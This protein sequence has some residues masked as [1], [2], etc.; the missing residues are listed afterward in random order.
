MTYVGS[1]LL[2]QAALTADPGAHS[3]ETNDNTNN[4][5][6]NYAVT[7]SS[8]NGY[9]SSATGITW[10]AV[11]KVSAADIARSNSFVWIVENDATGSLASSGSYW[12]RVHGDANG[13]GNGYVDASNTVT[14]YDIQSAQGSIVPG[15]VYHIAFSYDKTKGG[16]A[17][18]NGAASG[19]N[20]ATWAPVWA[21]APAPFF[22]ATAGTTPVGTGN[23][24]YSKQT[25]ISDVA[26][27]AK[28]LPAS[29]MAAHYAA[30]GG[31]APSPL[32]SPSPTSAPT[33]TPV[34]GALAPPKTVNGV[35]VTLSAAQ[36]L[37]IG[38]IEYLNNGIP[39]G[40][41]EFAT[42]GF[43][44]S[45]WAQ[46]Q[47]R[48]LSPQASWPGLQASWG[49]FQFDTYFGDQSDGSGNDPF[50]VLTD[51]VSGVQALRILAEPMPP[52]MKTN[53]L[54]MAGWTAG[55][56]ARSFVTPAAGSSVTITATARNIVQQGWTV[57]IGR[58]KG[59]QNYP[60]DDPQGVVFTGTVTDGGCTV[61]G[62]GSCTGG[63]TA[64]TLANVHYSEGGAGATIP[65]NADIQAWSSADYYSGTLDLNVNI[66][67]GYFSARARLP[68]YEPGIDAAIWTLQTGGEPN[69]ASG[70][71]RNEDDI[72][73]TFG[74]TSGNALNAGQ[75]RWNTSPKQFWPT[76]TGVYSWPQSGVPS[77]AYHDYGVLLAKGATTFYLDGVP[78]AGHQ[79]GPDWTNGTADKEFMAMIQVGAPGSWLDPS[80]QAAQNPWPLFMWLQYMR[81]YQPTSN[82]CT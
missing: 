23:P 20:T 15:K 32:P 21:S 10:E 75:I 45:W 39:S 63:S 12:L 44:R 42:N 35:P 69:P 65:A 27:Y 13:D 36:A 60:E 64:I 37:C 4:G 66:E 81:I 22:I 33:P 24:A 79:G 43:N 59:S 6:R 9:P 2:G 71:L 56:L 5:S 49:R 46:T 61:Q 41:G 17:Y 30:L 51:P 62:D 26:L 53:T 52:A 55:S 8:P 14:G 18:V 54:Y 76:P 67:Y 58:P 11:V 1:N 70:I 40:N 25:F 38:G 73:E 19:T 29:R 34:A 3:Y 82:S 68:Q 77:D 28:T 74:Q 31:V 80:S 78:I 57:G 47:R 7:A 50:N 16:V 48:T 72:V